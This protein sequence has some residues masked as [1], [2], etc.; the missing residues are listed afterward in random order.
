MKSEK[1]RVSRDWLS[2]PR[3]NL[4]GMTCKKRRLMTS[5]QAAQNIILIV[6]EILETRILHV[7][8]NFFGNSSFMLFCTVNLTLN[9]NILHQNSTRTAY[10]S[11][12]ANSRKILELLF[13][14]YSAHWSLPN[15]NPAHVSRSIDRGR[16]CLTRSRSLNNKD[17]DLQRNQNFGTFWC[18]LVPCWFCILQPR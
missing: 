11:E 1:I 10:H 2:F 3:N 13:D 12:L 8:C 5:V 15:Q 6:C 18:R 14:F 7:K 16:V 4:V 17:K 9:G